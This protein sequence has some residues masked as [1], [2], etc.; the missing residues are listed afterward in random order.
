[1]HALETL[2]LQRNDWVPNN[3]ILP[4]L[5]Y[6]DVVT[7]GDVAS[8]M[9]ALFT[10]NGWKPAWRD[11]VFD[12][13]HYHSTAHE[14]L[15]FAAGSARLILGGPQGVEVTVNKGDVV[16]LPAGTGHCRL[17]ASEDFLVVGGYPPGQNWDICREAP[18]EAMI[19]R[20]ARL[21]FPNSDPVTGNHPPLTAHWQGH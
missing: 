13:H 10:R 1:M 3:P 5:H 2:L 6:R 12:Y 20:I 4:V 14:V 7:D 15:G 19:E 18:T 11:G 17:S 16:L 21:P 8:A 9:E